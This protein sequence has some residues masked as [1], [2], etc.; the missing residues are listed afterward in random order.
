[1]NLLASS[2]LE[3]VIAFLVIMG[4]SYLVDWLRRKNSQNGGELPADKP[5]LSP[6][7]EPVSRGHSP[8]SPALPPSAPPP[9]SPWEVELKR[10]LNPQEIAPPP[11]LPPP[12]PPLARSVRIP[13]RPPLPQPAPIS[14][15]EV[16]A[17]ET[18]VPLPVG[19]NKASGVE[20]EARMI[21]GLPERFEVR[22]AHMGIL[23]EAARVQKRAQGISR[24]VADR[25]RQ[26]G[27]QPAQLTHAALR[28]PANKD[29][30][31]FVLSLHQPRGVRQA[32][33]ASVVLAPPKALED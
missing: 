27:H 13:E 3:S 26:A 18:H 11:P 21:A 20:D 8:G 24:Q 5:D 33:L 1:M 31:G 6:A 29:L 17:G 28:A 19:L 16:E 25:M 30:A 9:I 22:S 14:A 4:I 7:E 15:E 23:Q 12:P 32:I 2:S 10:L